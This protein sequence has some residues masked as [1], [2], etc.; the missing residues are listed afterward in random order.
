MPIQADKSSGKATRITTA[1]NAGEPD[2]TTVPSM[3][4]G[5][6][7]G[8][9]LSTTGLVFSLQRPATVTAA[10]PNTGGFGV[11]IWIRNPV[12]LSWAS[13]ETNTVDYRQAF[14]CFEFNASDL[15]FQIAAATVGT[16]GAII[17]ES[18]EQ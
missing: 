4:L 17:V 15:Y 10:E 2:E 12:T 6:Q 9:G 1:A 11:T 3:T 16:P 14:D 5:P 18:M 8:A 13:G 7:A